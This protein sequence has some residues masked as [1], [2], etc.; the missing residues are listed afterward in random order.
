MS[1]IS[2]YDGRVG[3]AGGISDLTS[4]FA[5]R[6][7]AEVCDA[8]MDGCAW[9]PTELRHAVGVSAPAMSSC[10]GHLQDAGVVIAIRQGKH[11]YYRLSSRQ[12]ADAIET[13]GCMSGCRLEP[14]VGYRKVRADARLRRA[15]TCYRHIAGHLGVAIADAMIDK[16]LIAV[17]DGGFSLTKDGKSWFAANIF[18]STRPKLST[19]P[20]VKACLDWTERR[21]HLSGTYGAAMCS[22]LLEIGA[23]TRYEPRRALKVTQAGRA[24]FADSLGFDTSSMD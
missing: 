22:R 15:R 3:M 6:T 17:N 16:G 18:E 12:A 2:Q 20:C 5:D 9:T 14:K 19:S 23:V 13:L 4:V 24:W 1:Q 10:L 11:R 7:R 21:P 8:L